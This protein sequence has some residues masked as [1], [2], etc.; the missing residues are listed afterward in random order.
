MF[1][2]LTIIDYELSSCSCTLKIDGAA[3]SNNQVVLLIRQ[4]RF[5]IDGSDDQKNT[6]YQIPILVKTSQNLTQVHMLK[7]AS[8][9]ITVTQVSSSEWVTVSYPLM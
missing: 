5:F 4:R 3:Y 9:S 7:D 8:G 1:F 6:I 2:Y